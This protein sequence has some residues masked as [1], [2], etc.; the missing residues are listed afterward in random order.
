MHSLVDHPNELGGTLQRWHAGIEILNEVLDGVS[1]R[2]TVFRYLDGFDVVSVCCY[3][4][5]FGLCY[6]S[7][8]LAD[9][10]VSR[11]INKE[12]PVSMD[13]QSRTYRTDTNRPPFVF[14]GS[15]SFHSGLV[16]PKKNRLDR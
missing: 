9:S 14:V 4:L 6:N 11:R 12:V 10:S 7:R 8:G 3:R 15:C 5:Y 16:Q 13:P 1:S 2:P